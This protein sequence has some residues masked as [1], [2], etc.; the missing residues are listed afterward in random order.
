[1]FSTQQRNPGREDIGVPK[2][3]GKPS[4]E[5]ELYADEFCSNPIPHASATITFL[6]TVILA[7]EESP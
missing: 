4:K 6:S 7:E 5:V 2:E 1:M 3:I